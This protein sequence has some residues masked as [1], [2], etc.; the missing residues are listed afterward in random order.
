MHPVTAHGFNFGLQGADALARRVRAAAAKGGDIAAPAL[1]RAYERQHRLATFPTYAAT[2]AT[3]RL[4]TDARRPVRMLRDVMLR[5]G[6]MAAP[7]RGLI[8]RHLMESGG[9]K[10][11]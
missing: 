8:T 4:F 11:A 5:V 6:N 1:L 3:V 9:P 7:V 2:N 10:P